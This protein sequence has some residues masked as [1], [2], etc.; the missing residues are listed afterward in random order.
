V[1]QGVWSAAPNA[2]RFD[3]M[4]PFGLSVFKFS[5]FDPAIALTS[6][7]SEIYHS[8]LKLTDPLTKETTHEYLLLDSP[9]RVKDETKS[10]KMLAKIP[11]RF[12]VWPKDVEDYTFTLQ[13]ASNIVAPPTM[14]GELVKL[15]KGPA[16]ESMQRRHNLRPFMLD[17][18]NVE[19]NFG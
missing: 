18:Y 12:E 14:T 17:V 16:I 5:L 4:L 9:R 8:G 19:Y 10:L 6:N 1:L 7:T 13:I 11:I 2:S 15:D 3:K